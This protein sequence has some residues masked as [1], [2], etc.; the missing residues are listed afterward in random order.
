VLLPL[1]RPGVVTA[2]PNWPC[3]LL[4]AFL[5]VAAAAAHLVYLT[6]DCPIDLAPDEAHYWDWSRHLDFSYYSKGPLVA[7]MIRASCTLF[8][9]TMP[10]VRLPAVC[11]GALVLVSL[12]VLTVQTFGRERLALGV[13]AGALTLPVVNV[14]AS[15]M[16][17]DAPYTCCWGWALVCA[18]WA[19]FRDSQRA[20][21]ATGL[22]VGVGI[23]AKYTMVV[24]VPSLG[25]FLLTTAGYRQQLWRRGFWIASAVAAFCCLPILIW[26]IRNDWVTWHHLKG[27]SGLESKWS[28]GGPFIYLGEQCA[29][30]L[31]FWFV[32]WLGAMMVHHPFKEKDADARYL[33]WMSAPMFL[34][35]FAFSFKTNGGEVNWPVTAYLSGFV[36]TAAWLTRQL[37]SPRTWYRRWTYSTLTLACVGGLA[38]S[39]FIHRMELLYP[40]LSKVVGAE[41]PTDPMP[42]RRIDPSCRLRGFRHLTAEVDEVRAEV[43]TAEGKEPVVAGASWTM[44]GH[45]GFYCAGHPQAYSVGLP[46]GDRHSQYDLWMNPIDEPQKFA[47][48]PFVLVATPSDP[49]RAAFER[50]EIARTVIHREAG[51]QVSEWVILVG[52]G[53]RGFPKE[54]TQGNRF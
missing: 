13:V 53:Y 41:K 33:W 31:I 46:L 45:L 5:I 48:R 9:D 17:I 52:Y 14:G 23:L 1:R 8:G 28:L 25:L 50:L 20:W 42:M 40:L 3:R 6:H 18:H 29:L 19:I 51:H 12:Y 39:F 37:S 10:A 15:I 44:P 7:W 4:A 36:L 47:D 34:L 54:P 2:A 30:Y 43:R 32:A 49:L 38:A 21:I 11:C 35:F 24:F 16:T 27:L 22:L 26:N